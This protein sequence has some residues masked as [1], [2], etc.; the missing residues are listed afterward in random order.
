VPLCLDL[1]GDFDSTVFGEAL[2]VLTDRVEVLRTGLVP[3]ADGEPRQVI[4]EHVEVRVDVRP[5]GG[6]D[7]LEQA[8]AEAIRLVEALASRP[9][10]LTKAPPFRAHTVPYAPGRTLCLLVFHHTAIDGW[11]TDVLARTLSDLYRQ[12]GAGV[13]QRGRETKSIPVRQYADFAVWQRSEPVAVDDLDYWRVQLADLAPLRLPTDRETPEPGR[14]GARLALE[15]PAETAGRLADLTRECAATRFMTSL[16]LYKLALSRWTGCDDVAVGIP[17]SGREHAQTATMIGC[18]TNTLVLRDSSGPDISFRELLRTVRS[19]SIEAFRH[20]RIPFDLL[21]E[22]L[23]PERVRDRTPLFQVAMAFAVG[24]HDPAEW[25]LH[26]VDRVIPVELAPAGSHF[27]LSLGVVWPL[28]GSVTLHLDYDA[29]LFESTTVSRFAS[30]LVQ[31]AVACAENPDTAVREHPVADPPQT[32]Q[33]RG[34]VPGGPPALPVPATQSQGLG[35]DGVDVSAATPMSRPAAS[36]LAHDIRTIWAE[37]LGRPDLGPDEDFFAAGGHSLLA[38]RLLIRMRTELGVEVPLNALMRQRTVA[39]LTAWLDRRDGASET[40]TPLVTLREGSSGRAFVLLHSIGASLMCYDGLVTALDPADAVY[41]LHMPVDLDDR[42]DGLEDLVAAYARE[43]LATIADPAPTVVGWSVGGVLAFE[44]AEQLMARGR[45]PRLVVIDTHMPSSATYAAGALAFADEL[46]DLGH[47]VATRGLAALGEPP[48]GHIVR[49]LGL[50]VSELSLVDPAEF[51]R[52]AEGWRQL[53]LMVGRYR[54]Q[55]ADL[56]V[57]L[58]L[59]Q[60]KPDG[61]IPLMQRSW[62]ELATSLTVQ[63]LPGDHFSLMS[64]PAVAGLAEAVRDWR[65]LTDEMGTE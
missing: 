57:L 63:V 64:V 31:L 32:P 7:T 28:N 21:V 20:Q 1:T 56:P 60:E 35:E 17:V 42:Y 4:H 34:A 37:I 33:A 24:A 52:L 27:D 30:M 2:G 40:G 55:P 48:L 13:L 50:S 18:F 49:S 65:S 3:D 39:D 44:F 41:G 15:L 12:V 8:R 58:A 6:F 19:T 47:A 9:F 16:A 51:A 59:S 45:A 23:R 14:A 62:S 11:S 43:V 36:A 54:P 5:V 61:E 38:V 46:H 53:S 10:D 29:E 25:N 26:G 22:R